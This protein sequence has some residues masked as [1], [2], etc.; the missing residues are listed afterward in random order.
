[1]PPFFRLRP[2]VVAL[3]APQVAAG[4]EAQRGHAP[5]CLAIAKCPADG[6]S[7]GQSRS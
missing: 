6:V 4:R 7:N 2:G 3:R 1:M 5:G